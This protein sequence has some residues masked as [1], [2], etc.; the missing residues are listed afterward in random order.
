[1]SLREKRIFCLKKTSHGPLYR[2]SSPFLSRMKTCIGKIM[3]INLAC[4]LILKSWS[5]KI[6]K[7]IFYLYFKE[8]KLKVFQKNFSDRSCFK[9][10]CLFYRSAK[11]SSEHCSWIQQSLGSV[12]V[13]TSQH[14]LNM[15]SELKP[16]NLTW[17]NFLPNCC[18]YLCLQARQL[19]LHLSRPPILTTTPGLISTDSRWPT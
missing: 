6:G 15:E 5:F 8:T 11:P 18:F 4:N 16:A 17:L 19:V 9:L 3:S 7:A 14:W 12:L 1:M 13:T 10:F 2:F